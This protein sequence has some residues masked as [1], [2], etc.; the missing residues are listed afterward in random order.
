MARRIPIATKFF[1]TYFVITGTALAFAGVAGYLQ[2]QRYAAEEVDR[3]LENQARIVAGIFLPF[4][5]APVPDRN[6]I[7]A[8]ADR[9]GRELDTR[10]TVVL[11]GGT[12]AADSRVGTGKVPGM[13]NHAGH[14]EIAEALAGKA[15]FSTRR[16][17]TVGEEQRYFAIP[18][19]RNGTV[20]GVVRVSLPIAF[21]NRRLARVRAITWGTGFAAF[22]LMLAGTAIRARHV[23]GPL[24]EMGKAARELADGNLRR[25]V[26]V[27]TGDELQDLAMA[28]N[29]TA[30]RLERAILER[31]SETA[32]LEAILGNIEEGVV[33]IGPDRS[34]RNINRSAL[35][36]LGIDGPPPPGRP[37]PE[38]IRHPGI[39]EFIES[40]PAEGSPAPRELALSLPAGERWVR[41]FGTRVRLP[42]NE[43]SGLL[44]TLLDTTGEKRLHRVKSDFVSN[45]SHE[46][47]TPL[48]NIRGYLEAMQDAVREGTPPDP[49]FL[50]IAHA[51][52]LRM[53]QMIEDLLELSRTES[54]K[55]QPEPEEIRLPDLLDRLRALHRDAAERAGKTLL[56]EREETLFRGDPRKLLLALS[57]LVDNGIKHGK[58]R[59]TVRVFGRRE[60]N[61]VRIDVE[62]DGPGIA[63]E[64]LPRIFERFYRADKGRS[65]ERGGTGLGLSIARHVVESHGGT[66]RVESRIGT[67]SRF[68]VLL[69]DRNVTPT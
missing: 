47:R 2:F 58:E 9:V 45:A 34:I 10:L 64:H 13:E 56:F 29:R 46:L 33:F 35:R 31:E 48:T 38:A 41:L 11:P 51:N 68:T 27:R 53:E 23:T 21:L 15:A 22:L 54:G 18:V 12:V 17:I 32:G 66:I 5:S 67:G 26:H 69:P 6:G 40:C 57:N 24:D 65:R 19:R 52:A 62:D 37:Y 36:I 28:L 30:S 8:E 14:P 60:G 1:L 44:L 4:L 55:A 16:S 63:A 50:S 42:G 25:R 20:I 3:T 43:D 39:L 59:G 61:A 7:A 49:S